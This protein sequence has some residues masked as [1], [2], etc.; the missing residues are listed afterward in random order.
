[1]YLILQAKHTGHKCCSDNPL[2]KDVLLSDETLNWEGD[3][4]CCFSATG[5]RQLDEIEN[6]TQE[7]YGLIDGKVSELPNKRVSI[8]ITRIKSTLA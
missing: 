8:N 7:D 5:E 6:L 4:R 3:K 2:L 1:M